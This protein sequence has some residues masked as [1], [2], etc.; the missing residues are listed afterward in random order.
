MEKKPYTKPEA[1]T[2][3]NWIENPSL[4]QGREEAERL[5]YLLTSYDNPNKTRYAELAKNNE[6]W[7]AD[8]TTY[9]DSGLGDFQTPYGV[10]WEELYR[11]TLAHVNRN[12][13][14]RT[15]YEAI[16]V[17]IK[18]HCK[19]SVLVDLGGNN[20]DIFSANNLQAGMYVGVNRYSD[21]KGEVDPRKPSSISMGTTNV[22]GLVEISSRSIYVKADMLDFVSRMPDASANFTINGI[23]RAI[24][25]DIEYHKALAV[26]IA[27]ATRVGGV[28]FGAGSVSLRYLNTKGI[29][30]Y[31]MNDAINKRVFEK[32]A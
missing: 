8:K 24:I 1:R 3:M 31:E 22:H 18:E 30:E 29:K 5:L 19:D 20:L 7:A 27:R 26:E 9:L 25:D 17:F 10:Q 4:I 28:I 16:F 21:K 32:I 14:L 15:N 12:E 6:A 23:D 13:D 11:G 2:E